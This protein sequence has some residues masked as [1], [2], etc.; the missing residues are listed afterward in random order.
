MAIKQTGVE[1]SPS[2]G[3]A[4]KSDL[5]IC[6]NDLSKS[7]SQLGNCYEVIDFD[8]TTG[9]CSNGLPPSCILAGQQGG[10]EV[11]SVEVWKVSMVR[12]DPKKFIV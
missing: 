10:W 7:Y 3:E 1:H 6:F 9:L 4:N 2:F 5:F 12:D 11:K 8:K